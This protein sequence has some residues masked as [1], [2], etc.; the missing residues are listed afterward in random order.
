MAA[1]K[2]AKRATSPSRRAP[3]LSSKYYSGR[4]AEYRSIQLLEDAGFLCIRAAGSK[5]PADVV[6]I[7]AGPPLLVQVK[8]AIRGGGVSKVEREK[9]QHVK[10]TYNCRVI[11]HLWRPHARSPIMEE[12][13]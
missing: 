7:G 2:K 1:A 6:A 3:R 10:R 4:R 8:R 12:I 11:V 9:L 13:T 5:G